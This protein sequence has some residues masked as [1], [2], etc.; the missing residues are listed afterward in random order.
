MRINVGI[1]PCKS[2]VG[3]HFHC[4]LV[5]AKLGPGEQGQAEVNRGRIQRIQTLIQFHS[6]GVVSIQRPRDRDQRLR[7]VG[8]YPPVA[9]FIGI[10]QCRTSDRAAEAHVV[11]LATKGPQASLDVAKA[12]DKSIAQRPWRETGRGITRFG[13]CNLRNNDRHMFGIHRWANGPST[14]RRRFDRCSCSNISRRRIGAWKAQMVFAQFKSKK[15]KMT[16]KYNNTYGLRR[17]RMSS[18]GQ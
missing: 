11:K 3:V 14:E 2:S 5:L 4:C 8:I 16:V 18:T 17:S 10:A 6:D 13:I 9:R 12:L 7:K 15:V 1:L